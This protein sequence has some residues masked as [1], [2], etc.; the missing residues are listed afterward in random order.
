VERVRIGAMSDALAS[1]A[2]KGGPSGQRALRVRMIDVCLYSV[3][4]TVLGSM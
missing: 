3:V 2:V 4:M 1:R